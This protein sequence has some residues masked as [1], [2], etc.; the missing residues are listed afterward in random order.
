MTEE[1]SNVVATD[2]RVPFMTNE[3]VIWFAQ[4]EAGFASKR[5][6]SQREKFNYTVSV[7]PPAVALEVKDIILQPPSSAPYD[8]LKEQVI[9]RTSV[10]EQKKL[11][12]LLTIEALGDRKPTQLLRSMRA[13][14]GGNR[15]DALLGHIFLQRLPGW[16]QPILAAFNCDTEL[17]RL[18]EAADNILERTLW[19]PTMPNIAHTAV[20][21]SA[22][23]E[24]LM[25]KNWLL[26]KKIDL[27]TKRMDELVSSLDT[28]D[29]PRFRSRSRSPT[30]IC[31]K[32][33]KFGKRAWGCV[34]PCKYYNVAGN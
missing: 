24:K 7:L 23:E 10:S 20:R 30:S 2:T 8:T 1:I 33:Q 18:A 15:N 29:N 19:T 31:W 22:A 12:Q 5:I 11:Q 26:E 28:R 3:P 16:M 25:E 34:K 21:H 4:L 32:H 14:A 27:L 9:S 6:T 13:L 17:D